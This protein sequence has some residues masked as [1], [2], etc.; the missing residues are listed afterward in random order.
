MGYQGRS[1]H[2]DCLFASPQNFCYNTNHDGTKNIPQNTMLPLHT[3]PAPL[4]HLLR[5]FLRLGNRR[6]SLR[7]AWLLC[8]PFC[9]HYLRRETFSRAGISF[10]AA[11]RSIGD[12]VRSRKPRSETFGP[13]CQAD[14]IISFMRRFLHRDARPLRA[15]FGA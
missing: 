11:F 12:P 13:L 3:H 4:G 10:H 7:R 15:S 2:S 9:H 5:R 14:C 1:I 6:D 8:K